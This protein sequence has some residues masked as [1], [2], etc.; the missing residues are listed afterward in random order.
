MTKAKRSSFQVIAQTLPDKGQGWFW[1]VE[2]AR[3]DGLIG[4][5]ETKAEAIRDARETL[6]LREGEQ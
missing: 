6:E 2:L 5:F 4:P 1:R 3:D